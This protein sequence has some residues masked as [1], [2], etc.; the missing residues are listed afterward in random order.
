MVGLAENFHESLQL[1]ENLF[2]MNFTGCLYPGRLHDLMKFDRHLWPLA[3]QSGKH[4]LEGF[5]SILQ[6]GSDASNLT[7]TKIRTKLLEDS[8][9]Q[10]WLH[11]DLA[12]YAKLEEIFKHQMLNYNLTQT[13]IQELENPIKIANRRKVRRY[14]N[15]YSHEKLIE[16]RASVEVQDKSDKDR[17]KHEHRKG[18]KHK[19]NHKDK[20][21]KNYMYMNVTLGNDPYSDMIV[22]NS[23]K[24]QKHKSKDDDIHVPNTD[25]ENSVTINN[26]VPSQN[27]TD[28]LNKDKPH[29]RKSEH[30]NNKKEKSHK[31]QTMSPVHH[32]TKELTVNSHLVN[33][34][35]IAK[36]K[37]DW[38]RANT[39]TV[40]QDI[41]TSP[42]TLNQSSRITTIESHMK[43]QK[44]NHSKMDATSDKDLVAIFNKEIRRP[45]KLQK[46]NDENFTKV[47]VTNRENSEKQP[48]KMDQ[49]VLLA[50]QSGVDNLVEPSYT[51]QKHKSGEKRKHRKNGKN[52]PEL[53]LKPS[54]KK[55]HNEK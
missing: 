25:I 55:K 44:K 37:N 36:E 51:H 22:K 50:N 49:N 4:S 29:K 46:R 27:R 16:T 47:D 19:K 8:Q 26:E 7:Y 33:S 13:V 9:V 42:V 15:K 30:S 17:T 28:V 6:Y 54:S 45:V 20:E 31:E 35:S 34:H 1:Y 24:K 14:G 52:T 32:E 48:P 10:K 18:H 2:G 21:Q 23:N 3:L 41:F 12:I 38:T 53:V 11:A 39:P 40:H 43:N 5:E